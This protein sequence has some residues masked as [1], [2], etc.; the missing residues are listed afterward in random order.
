MTGLPKRVSRAAKARPA[1]IVVPPRRPPTWIP[2]D[3]P[4]WEVTV[5]RVLARLA[6]RRRR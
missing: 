5:D 1:R 4:P 3:L 6:A 2:P